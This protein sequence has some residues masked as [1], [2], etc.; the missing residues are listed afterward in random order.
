MTPF[1][2]TRA[3]ARALTFVIVFAVKVAIAATVL[4]AGSAG[5]Q[6]IGATPS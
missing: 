5:A 3:V 6:L 2:V 1:I 4:V